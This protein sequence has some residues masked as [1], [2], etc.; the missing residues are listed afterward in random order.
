MSTFIPREDLA[1]LV[2][3]QGA[4]SEVNALRYI[5]QIGEAL[6]V[7]HAERLVA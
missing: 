2:E 5:Q 7:V 1:S 4:L 6:I 3:N